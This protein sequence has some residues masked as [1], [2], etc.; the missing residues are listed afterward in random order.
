MLRHPCLIHHQHITLDH[1]RL[2]RQ[3]ARLEQL[4]S[5]SWLTGMHDH[6]ILAA[7]QPVLA[8]AR[9]RPFGIDSST[10]GALA[11]RSVMPSG[12]AS[13]SKKLSA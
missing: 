2:H 11:G 1:L 6:V 7:I 5:I 8:E 9:H 3:Q 13:K 10:L 4:M 12:M